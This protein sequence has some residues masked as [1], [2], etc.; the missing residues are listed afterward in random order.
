MANPNLT[1]SKAVDLGYAAI[2]DILNYTIALKNN[3]DTSA[4]NVVLIDLIPQGANFINDSILVDSIS[5][6]Q[7][8]NPSLGIDIGTIIQGR[9]LTVTFKA[10]VVNIPTQNPMNNKVQADYQYNFSVTSLVNASI[11][12]NIAVTTI[13]NPNIILTKSL[14]KSIVSIGNVITYTVN[15]KNTG[16]I[17]ATNVTLID[18]IPTGTTLVANSVN[19][20]GVTLP[21]FSPAPPGLNIGTLPVN[22]QTNLVFSVTV[23]SIPANRIITN[24][25]DATYKFIV[26]PN[27]TLA[28]SSRA[29]SNLVISS[30]TRLANL[31]QIIEYVDKAYAQCGEVLKYTISILNKGNIDAYNIKFTSTIPKGTSLIANSLTV[32]NLLNVGATPSPPTGV[33]IGTI[34][35]GAVTTVSY[36]VKINCT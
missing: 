6:A 9:L 34:S 10:L 11:D 13:N 26:N 29:T 19:I 4:N 8:V 16:S 3:G 24:S 5:V 36:E 12:S 35:S 31:S 21:G 17:S 7:S 2:G 23:T 32:N 22:N 33:S 20:G 27:T 28:V 15:I 18:T 14:N 1:V 25:C 30:D